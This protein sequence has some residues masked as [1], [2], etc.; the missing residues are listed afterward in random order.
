MPDNK[1]L[2]RLAPTVG[3]HLRLD[4]SLQFG[5]DAR[6]AGV[7]DTLPGDTARRVRE[8]FSSVTVPLSPDRLTGVLTTAGVD[9]TAAVILVDELIG[10]GM[11]VPVAPENTRIGVLGEDCIA[12]EVRELIT[13]YGAEVSG[14]RPGERPGGFLRTF[15]PGA[16]VVITGAPDHLHELAEPV[17]QRGGD[18]I[19]VTV[20]DGRVVLG[21]IRF[22]GSGPCSFC[23]AL[24]RIDTDPDAPREAPRYANGSWVPPDPVIVRTAAAAAAALALRCAGLTTPSPGPERCLPPAGT[25]LTID[26]HRFT[27]THDSL[28]VHPHCP[29]CWA[30][31]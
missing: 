11:L 18:V 10:Y 29:A 6:W 28:G 12:D 27:T 23:A 17:L 16:P 22:S 20:I 15:S 21:P 24:H 7:V 4:G 3:V 13:G 25:V 26:P 30:A 31:A 14:R 8:I 1:N 9:P 5:L 2:I 19:P